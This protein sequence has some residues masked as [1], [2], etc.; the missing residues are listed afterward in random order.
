MPKTCPDP[1]SS[2]QG[3]YSNEECPQFEFTGEYLQL[4]AR[5]PSAAEGAPVPVDGAI[6]APAARV[7]SLRGVF[8]RPR[9]P[10]DL[11]GVRLLGRGSARTLW[12]PANSVPPPP[13]PGAAD[14]Q[15]AGFSPW[16]YPDIHP[17]LGK[18]SQRP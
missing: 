2:L 18:E 3:E 14:V 13:L 17:Q 5:P 12:L 10:A 6:R 9:G 1:P 15:G 11:E 16:C 8:V 4:E 7:L